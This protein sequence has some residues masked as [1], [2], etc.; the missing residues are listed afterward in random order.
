MNTCSFGVF[1]STIVV[2]VSFIWAFDAYSKIGSFQSIPE[3][4]R[5]PSLTALGVLLALCLGLPKPRKKQAV[6]EFS[7][8]PSLKDEVVPHFLEGPSRPRSDPTKQKNQ[9]WKAGPGKI[10]NGLRDPQRLSNRREEFWKI[11]KG[12]VKSSHFAPFTWRS[13]L[14]AG[15]GE[16]VGSISRG[17]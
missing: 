1:I 7:E 6:Q 3:T 8:L 15:V 4:P 11:R 16:Y 9:S 5:E 13:P 2:S 12:S 10:P 14:Q 17:S